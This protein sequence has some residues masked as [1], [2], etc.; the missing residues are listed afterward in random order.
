MFLNWYSRLCLC[1]NWMHMPMMS[2][3]FVNSLEKEILERYL[4][5]V[6]K[7]NKDGLKVISLF[8]FSLIFITFT[9]GKLLSF[10]GWCL[11]CIICLFYWVKT[12]K[13]W[14]VL[15]RRESIREPPPFLIVRSKPM[16]VV[17]LETIW[18]G[19]KWAIRIGSSVGQYTNH[20]VL[21]GPIHI[22]IIKK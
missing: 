6:L 5:V 20:L 14:H 7:G 19:T 18:N 10:Y 16:I 9:S 15:I 2:F 17:P 3:L 21:G 8:Q 12:M 13:W 1:L 11:I 22:Q 4:D